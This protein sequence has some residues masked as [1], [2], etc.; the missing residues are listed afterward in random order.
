MQRW[1]QQLVSNNCKEIDQLNTFVFEVPTLSNHKTKQNIIEFPF[2]GKK[3][4]FP[5]KKNS[6][7]YG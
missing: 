1:V 2:F 7:D 6:P 5:E 4:I 3:S